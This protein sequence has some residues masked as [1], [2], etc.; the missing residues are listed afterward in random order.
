MRVDFTEEEI[1]LL[2]EAINNIPFASYNNEQK[3][4]SIWNKLNKLQN[5]V[6]KVVRHE[7][8]YDIETVRIVSAEEGEEYQD[9]VYS[10]RTPVEQYDMV[11]VEI[12]KKSGEWEL[13]L[14]P[15]IFFA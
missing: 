9:Y 7:E 1:D 5:L 15:G 6:S 8:E 3:R 11:G 12:Q 13:I 4:L 14:F 2:K 10:D